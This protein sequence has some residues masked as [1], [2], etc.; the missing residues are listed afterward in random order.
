MVRKETGDPDRPRVHYTL[1]YELGQ[2]G[3]GRYTYEADLT[4]TAPGS[5]RPLT[6]VLMDGTTYRAV[7]AGRDPEAAYADLPS[8]VPA[9][10]NPL[11]ITTPG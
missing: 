10:S 11:L 4:T 2:Q 8:P 9:V 3:P 6:A 7:K 1:R 5:E